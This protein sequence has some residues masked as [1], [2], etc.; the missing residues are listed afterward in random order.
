[1]IKHLTAAVSGLTLAGSLGLAV[2]GS[3]PAGADA[4]ASR[5]ITPA[6]N[7]GLI[8][9]NDRTICAITNGQGAALTTSL[10]QDGGCGNFHSLAGPG[11]TTWIVNANGHAVREKTNRQIEMGNGSPQNSDTGAQWTIDST[12]IYNHTTGDYI[13]APCDCIS[14]TVI[15]RLPG[16]G[17]WRMTP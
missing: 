10:Y 11:G 13:S 12:G 9:K 4:R 15:G 8:L 3:A 17:G 2:A 7:Y 14:M 16:Q 6:V 5:A 1:M